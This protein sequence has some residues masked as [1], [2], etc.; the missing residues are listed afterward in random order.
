MKFRDYYETLEV[1]RQ[2]SEADIKQA[3]RRL[4]RKYHPD[5]NPGD[6]SAERHFKEVNEAHE[7]LSKKETR[8]HYD[9]LGQSW[10]AYDQTHSHKNRPRAQSPFSSFRNGRSKIDGS[11]IFDDRSFSD[12]FQTFF[13]GSNGSRRKT[14]NS[15]PKLLEVSLEQAFRGSTQKLVF[16]DEL[17][18]RSVEIRI[19]PGITDNTLI[20]V[21]PTATSQTKQTIRLRIKISPH[22]TFKLSGKNLIREQSVPLLTAILGGTIETTGLDGS[23]FQLKIPAGTQNDQIFRLK[24]KGMPSNRKSS[25]SG[26]LLITVKIKIPT[27]L[28]KN[29]RSHYEALASIEKSS[30]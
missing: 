4:A 25:Q 8:R 29:S 30:N 11:G 3:Y 6:K 10:R 15:E 21:P 12:F 28:S 7:V 18:T 16:H 13:D 9:E 20:K 14:M 24:G 19:P 5:V 26:N 22:A 27:R 23:K 17:H 1:S 2:A